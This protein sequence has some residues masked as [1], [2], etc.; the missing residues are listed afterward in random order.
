MVYTFQLTGITDKNLEDTIR[1]KVMNAGYSDIELNDIREPVKYDFLSSTYN[2]DNIMKK[3]MYLKQT[4]SIIPD[5][6]LNLK[7]LIRKSINKLTKLFLGNNLNSQSITNQEYLDIL[8]E[9]VFYVQAQN[10]MINK[11]KK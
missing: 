11:L 5:N 6:K 8:S 10:E 4:T 9:L 2:F 1:D 7:I 3:I